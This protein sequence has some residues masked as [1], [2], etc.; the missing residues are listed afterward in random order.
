VRPSGTLAAYPD[1]ADWSAELCIIHQG[2]PSHRDDE[3][4]VAFLDEGATSLQAAVGRNSTEHDPAVTDPF[5][6][7][8]PY[9]KSPVYIDYGTNLHVGKRTFINRNFVVIDSPVCPVWIGDRCQLGPN[10][11]LAAVEHPLNAKERLSPLGAPSYASSIIIGDDCWIAAGVIILCGVTIGSG[12][13][14]GAGS[15]VTKV[16]SDFP[17]RMSEAQLKSANRTSQVAISRTAIQRKSRVS[18]HR[19]LF[20]TFSLIMEA[21]TGYRSRPKQ[22]LWTNRYAIVNIIQGETTPARKY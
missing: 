20:E 17:H 16:F 22:V 21:W 7:D 2:E 5:I 14:V 6:V 18:Y 10:V 4:D 19:L 8:V 15:V 11:T 12:C 1:A 13:V 9:V 3:E